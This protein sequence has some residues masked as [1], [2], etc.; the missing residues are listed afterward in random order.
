V[1]A[2][3][4]S[5][6]KNS[7]EGDNNPPVELNRSALARS[8]G[9]APTT[10]DKWVLRGCPGLKVEGSWRFV[11]A[12]VVAWRN[13]QKN[14]QENPDGDA[15]FAEARRRKAFIDLETAEYELAER[16]RRVV[17]IEEAVDV[18]TR[19]FSRVR[20]KLLTLPADPRLASVRDVLQPAIT[21]ILNELS[22]PPH[23]PAPSGNGGA[24]ASH[25]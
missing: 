14:D 12:D 9:V 19:E 23:L 20:A 21:E 17:P 24:S 3:H 6:L 11:E 2:R 13:A 16:R 18:L 10:V 8:Q 5:S 4:S 25:S 1:R 15:T 22:S 7:G